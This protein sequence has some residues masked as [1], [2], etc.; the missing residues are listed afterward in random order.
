MTP[1]TS[2]SESPALATMSP[3]QR[4]AIRDST[5]AVERRWK[6]QMTMATIERCMAESLDRIL[7]KAT[8]WTFVPLIVERLANDRLRA[9]AQMGLEPHAAT[10]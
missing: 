10:A 6:G 2:Q 8:V 1:P 3:A 7:P 4:V 9:M 5:A